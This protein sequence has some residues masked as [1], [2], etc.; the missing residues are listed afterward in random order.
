MYL[1]Q[2][3]SVSSLFSILSKDILELYDTAKSGNSSVTLT[4]EKTY[5]IPS[6]M[7]EGELDNEVKTVKM[8]I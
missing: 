1:C 5:L 7:F 2:M 8:Y 3:L 4:S 6:N